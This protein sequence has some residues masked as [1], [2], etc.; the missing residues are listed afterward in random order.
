VT[1][2]EQKVFPPAPPAALP[3][4]ASTLGQGAAAYPPGGAVEP[5]DPAFLAVFG[6]ASTGPAQSG[7]VGS[8]P[9]VAPA[10]A[11]A[12]AS[13]RSRYNQAQS[14]LKQKR[15]PQAA[16]AFSEMLRDFPGGRL[17]PNARYW[18]GE[19]RYAV[20]DFSGALIEFRQGLADYPQS[21]KAPDY[22]LKMSYC[23]SQLG[24][25]PGAMESLRRLLSV[26]PE[27]DSAKMVKSGRSRFTGSL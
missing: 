8:P 6:P 23:Q 7:A 15:Y 3:P 9:L 25:G 13:E 11:Q 20:G 16:M 26:Y 17:A 21:N 1:R 19:C 5:L 2:L 24:D 12:S 22:L 10:P 27:S 14:L 4:D 18:L